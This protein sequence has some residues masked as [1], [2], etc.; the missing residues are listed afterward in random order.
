MKK[1]MKIVALLMTTVICLTMEAQSVVSVK[2]AS[3]SAR[4]WVCSKCKNPMTVER[5]VVYR[6]KTEFACEVKAH[7][8]L[9]CKVEYD[10]YADEYWITCVTCGKSERQGE[11][12]RYENP[13]HTCLRDM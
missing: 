11:D 10:T 6:G 2:A 8:S 5:R 1:R 7:Q 13:E 4:V 12:V 3:M 9:S